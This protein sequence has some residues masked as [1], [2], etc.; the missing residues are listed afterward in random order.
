M[1]TTAAQGLEKIGGG[2]SG[3]KMPE[4]QEVQAGVPARTVPLLILRILGDRS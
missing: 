1:Y 4:S 3:Y 2:W